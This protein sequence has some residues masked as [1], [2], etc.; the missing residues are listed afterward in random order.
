MQHASTT[1]DLT[2]VPETTGTNNS[3]LSGQYACYLMQYWQGGARGGNGQLLMR[4]GA[5]FA[6]S[7]DGNGHITGGEIDHNSL[8]SGYLSAG[9]IGALGGTYAVGADDRGYMLPSIGGNSVVLALAGGNLDSNSRFTEFA[10]IEM[11]DAG[12]S[13]SGQYGGGH[14]YKQNTTS[15]AQRLPTQRRL[16][17]GDEEARTMSGNLESQAG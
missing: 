4:G 9:D 10:M 5:V 8:I 6:F 1:Y 13:P 12:S 11:D 3:R 15:F 16:R 17:A 14:C 7:A 2:F